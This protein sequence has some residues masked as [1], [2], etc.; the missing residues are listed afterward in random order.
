MSHS[1]VLIF[2]SITSGH[3]AAVLQAL[4]VAPV[5]RNGREGRDCSGRAGRAGEEE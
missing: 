5:R 4:C 1:I 2:L 3:R